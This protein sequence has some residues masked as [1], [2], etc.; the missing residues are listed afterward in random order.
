MKLYEAIETIIGAFGKEII[1]NEKVINILNDYNAYEESKT[2]RIILKILIAEGYMDQ[3]LYV[4]DWSK[5]QDRFIN[6]VISATSFNE[7]NASYVIMS[8]AYGLGYINIAPTFQPSASFAQPTS[9]PAPNQQQGR[10]QNRPNIDPSSFRGVNLNKTQD[11]FLDLDDD[12][13]QEYMEAAEAYLESIIE[14]KT[15]FE[16][17]LGV[18]INTFIEFSPAASIIPKFEIEGKIMVEYKY[19][20][21]FYLLFYDHKDKMM[22][23]EDIYVGKKR[24]SYEVADVTVLSSQYNK[25]ENIKRIVV[26]WEK[27]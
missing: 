2:F 1:N 21:M 22:F 6:N 16:K 20:I 23:K 7:S 5:I 4:G 13:R 14:F 11:E 27:N 26:Y 25:V 15:D 3:M 9:A 19:S 12:S 17:E 8:L 10:N 24:S 18:K